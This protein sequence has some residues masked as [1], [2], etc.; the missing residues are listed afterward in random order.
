ME[1]LT[2]EVKQAV[3][4][5]KISET[6]ATELA[7]MT[8]EE[9]NASLEKH[10]YIPAMA[11][12]A[13]DVILAE[14]HVRADYG[15]PIL[16]IITVADTYDAGIYAIFAILVL[17][18]FYSCGQEIPGTNPAFLAGGKNLLDVH[19][20]SSKDVESF[21]AALYHVYC[22]EAQLLDIQQLLGIG[23]PTVKEDVLCPVSCCQGSLQEI[24]HNRS[25]LLAGHEPALPDNG[26]PV[27][28][29]AGA[30]NLFIIV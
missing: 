30:E 6:A 22:I 14:A 27:D 25:S 23:K 5:N 3:D 12:Y 11:V 29:V 20:F 10:F 2:D 1:K 16:A 19:G 8:P 28:L 24:Y 15:N 26:S 9:Q 13:D 4:E 21:A 7:T 18:N 17:A